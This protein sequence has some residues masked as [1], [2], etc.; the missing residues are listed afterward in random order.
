[1]SNHH[2]HPL[3]I[4]L[5]SCVLIL[6]ACGGPGGGGSGSSEVGSTT[7]TPAPIA[8]TLQID[9]QPADTVAASHDTEQPETPPPPPTLPKSEPQAPPP[10]PPT[11]SPPD[12]QFELRIKLLTARASP[13]AGSTHY[14]LLADFDGPT[15]PM[16]PQVAASSPEP[17]FIA[18][19]SLHRR[20]GTSY[21][22]RACNAGG[23]GPASA[24]WVPDLNGSIGY[25]K[26][27]NA[28]TISR[29]GDAVALS[30]DGSTLV[31]GAPGEM[32]VAAAPDPANPPEPPWDGLPDTG[33]VYV[34][35]RQGSGWSLQ[36]Y[37]KA[38]NISIRIAGRFG[39]SVALSADGNTLAVGAPGESSYPPPAGTSAL[40]GITLGGGPGPS[41]SPPVSQD[42]GA[43]YVF[44][45]SSTGQWQQT[46]H[47]KAPGGH[48]TAQLGYSVALSADGQ[49][50]AAGAPHQG[51][52]GAVYLLERAGDGWRFTVPN[53]PALRARAAAAAEHGEAFGFSV[54][55]SADGRV[56]AAG[57][58]GRH[59]QAGAVFSFRRSASGVW[60]DDGLQ[61]AAGGIPAGARF[62]HSVALS[63]DGS[64]LAAGAPHESS[65]APRSG[66]AYLF[67][68]GSGGGGWQAQAFLKPAQGGSDDLF[69]T[70]VALSASGRLLAV[71]APQERSPTTGFD[72]V[73]NRPGAATSSTFGAAYLFEPEGHGWRP[74]RFIKPTNLHASMMFGQSLALSADGEH[75]AVGAPQENTRLGRI[76]GGAPPA[77]APQTRWAGAVYLY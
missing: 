27:S 76:L 35:T 8:A 57:A 25:I 40:A 4:L 29:L 28:S 51:R 37:L 18:P 43:V 65:V 17:F 77:S 75:L 30:A 48:M 6:T 70:R 19:L 68:H 31:V 66:A 12:P 1:M 21:T 9:P 58:P 56:L 62:G 55:L 5:T 7:T 3:L 2:H 54:A 26:A 11:Q 67:T 59:H 39:A 42:S 32:G 23:C 33:A 38:S 50:L 61:G 20:A 69:G 64:T 15:A 14:E 63:A 41:A 44:L 10:P 16:E 52:S 46:A 47:V 36:A 34:F 74:S 53:G 60:E 49:Q 22:L 45:R 24:P 13:V 72:A 73:E 71:A